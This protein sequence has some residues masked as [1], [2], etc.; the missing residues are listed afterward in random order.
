MQNC[1]YLSKEEKSFWVKN[2]PNLPDHTLLNVLAAISESNNVMNESISAAIEAN[3]DN[4]YLKQITNKINQIK[5]HAFN[6]EEEDMKISAEQ[7]LEKQME[8]L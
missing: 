8:N 2:L 1:W 4:N 3:P 7:D 5:K 6:M